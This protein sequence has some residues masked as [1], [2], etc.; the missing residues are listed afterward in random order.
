MLV[1]TKV[2][3]GVLPPPSMYYSNNDEY[4]TKMLA[5]DMFRKGQ[6]TRLALSSIEEPIFP[7]DL[8]YYQHMKDSE[9]YEQILHM[10][11]KDMENSNQNTLYGR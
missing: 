8:N 5:E 6:I 11:D 9:F 1:G 3:L 10:T 7:A 4:S 2:N